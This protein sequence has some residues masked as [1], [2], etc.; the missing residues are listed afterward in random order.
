[1]TTSATERTESTAPDAV[2]SAVANEHRRVVLRALDQADEETMAVGTLVD[3][4]AEQVRA[5]D[6]ERLGD[7][8]RE[9]VHTALYH[10]HL[11]KLEASGMVVH[12]T[13]VGQVRDVTGELERD[14]LT[15]VESYEPRE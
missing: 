6:G 4:V 7:E 8:H 5:D 10:V 15:V 1:M 11:P 9:R 12:D 14:L 2:L 3:R 13:Q